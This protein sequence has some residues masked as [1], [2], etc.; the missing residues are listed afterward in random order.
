[1]LNLLTDDGLHAL[2]LEEVTSIRLLDERLNKELQDALLVL[3]TGLD[4]QRK[5]V[6]INFTGTGERHVLVGY[7]TEAPIWK[8]SYRLV[9]GETAERLPGLGGGGKYQRRGL[10]ECASLA[11]LRP[12]HQLHRRSVHPALHAP[13]RLPAGALRLAGAGELCGEPGDRLCQ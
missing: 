5:P 2:R 10:A 11:G 6:L 13:P 1:M 4:N 12:S 8:T 3:A 7:L 9:L